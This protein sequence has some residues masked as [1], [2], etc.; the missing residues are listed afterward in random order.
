MG[1]FAI[2]LKDYAKRTGQHIDAAVRDVVVTAATFIDRRSPVGNRELWASN[3]Y[4]ASRGLP[5][6]PKGYIGGHFRLNNQYRFGS[7][8]DSEIDGVDPTG[9]VSLSAVQAGV[10]GSPA[11]GVH[12][13]ANLCK[14]AQ[15]LEDGH[16][17]QTNHSPEGIYG[18]AAIDTANA[19]KAIF[20]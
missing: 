13:I 19:A 9:A 3:I 14:Y 15:A 6:A 4:R 1:T 16:S 8:P 7:L 18:L 12:Y 17:S 20:K 11:A 2:D 10:M 5:P